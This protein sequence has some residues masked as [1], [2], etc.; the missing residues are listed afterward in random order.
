MTSEP[1]NASRNNST[2][3]HAERR[4]LR[5]YVV[6]S[7]GLFAPLVLSFVFIRNVYPVAVWKVML[8]DP[9]APRGRT[10]FILR[11]ET[12]G[13]ETI[14][15]PPINLMGGMYGRTWWMAGA[16]AANSSFKLGSLHPENARM[17]AE[18]GGVERLPRGARLPELIRVWGDIYNERQPA[19][20]PRRLKAM[21][22]DAYRWDGVRFDD[23]EQFV[24]SWR[25]EL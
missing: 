3:R 16:T 20:S 15:I 6:L 9:E 13:G 2:T 1:L 12:V 24:E 22:L 14:D 19:G 25:A 7:V 4:L 5:R 10:Y 17:L 21:R 18:V 23:Y 11:G 8:L